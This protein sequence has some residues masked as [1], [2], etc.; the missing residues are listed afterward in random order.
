MSNI[1]PAAVAG[2][3]YPADP[4]DLDR[5]LTG[6][7]AA[8]PLPADEA[9]PKALIAPHAGYVYS[10]AVA[11][12]AYARIQSA[13]GRIQRVVLIGPS[14]RVAFR[15]LALS[16]AESWATPLGA[17]PLDRAA[18]GVL[19]QI[20]MVGFLDQAHAQEH[21]LEVH[22]PFLQKTLGPVALVPMV[23][24]DTPPETVA[25]A[26]EALWG[27]QETLIVASTD[28]S[29]FLDY[30]AC[31]ELDRKTAAAIAS[32]NGAALTPDGACGR[33][34]VA[35]LLHLAAARSMSIRT[36]DIRNSGDT[37]GPKDRVVGYGAWALDEHPLRAFSAVLVGLARTAIE[38]VFKNGTFPTGPTNGPD[39]LFEPGAVFV[40]LKRQGNLRGCIGSV[41]AWRNLGEDIVDNAAKAAFKDPRFPP[42]SPEEWP[43][44]TLSVTVITPSEAMSFS[45]EADFLRQL[46]PGQDGLRI[47]DHGKQALFI[48]SVWESLPHSHDFVAH[49]KAKAGLPPGHWSPS[50]KAWRF[51]A[52]ELK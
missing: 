40:T 37:A 10:G 4:Q 25:A 33:F 48:P 42:L 6:L 22:L 19:S 7:L 46:R 47:E 36:L 32:L 16:Q 51:R 45:D 28:L 43:E 34:P 44:I 23:V 1:R 9:A 21:S 38:Y 39:L 12:Q 24:G 17:M 18:Y 13:R 27:G 29:H 5:Q 41:S 26:L 14:H 3:F 35:G 20:P 50:F 2:S 49:L 15:G 52:V 31:Q 30:D 8:V 11:A